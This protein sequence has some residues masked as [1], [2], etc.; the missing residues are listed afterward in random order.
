[1]NRFLLFL[2]FLFFLHGVQ[3]QYTEDELNKFISSSSE[4][5]QVMETSLLM[6][7][8]FY[9]YAEKIT[10]NLLSRQPDNC[11][12][13]YRK[14]YLIVLSRSDYFA[15]LP[16]L[17]KAITSL[18]KNFDR[19]SA[20]EKSAS[21]DALYYLACCYHAIG[22]TDDATELFRKFISMSDKKATLVTLSRLKIKQCEL[23]KELMSHPNVNVSVK[24]AGPVINSKYPEYSAI[25]ALDGSALFYTSRRPWEDGSSDPYVD[26]R[27]NL[28]PEDVYVS[29][30]D[31]NN[32]WMAPQR[33]SF[34][35]SETFEATVAV[36]MDERRVYVYKDDTG[37]GDIY[38]SDFSQ[39]RFKEMEFL[40]IKDVNTKYW[41]PHAT[42]NPE[43]TAMYIVSDRPGGYGGRDIYQCLKQKDGTWG[44]PVN[45]GPEINS[46]YD[47]DAPFISIDGKQFYFSTNGPKSMG[48]FDIL[49]SVRTSKNKWSEAVNLGYPINSCGDDLY[50][51]TTIDGYHGYFTSFRQD[52]SGEKDIYEVTNNYLG[53]KDLCFLKGQFITADH[54]AL[55]ENVSITFR[56][57]D[58]EE[59]GE[60]TVF[61]RLRDGMIIKMLEPCKEYEMV[62]KAENKELLRENIKTACDVH[63]SIVEKNMLLDVDKMTLVPYVKKKDTVI[64]LEEFPLVDMK[65]LESRH[66]FRYDD[67]KLSMKGRDL[68]K[69]M[70][71]VEDQLKDRNGNITVKVYSSASNV[72]TRRYES[73]QKLADLRAENVKYDIVTHFQQKKKY[74]GRV[75]VVIVSSVVE[76]PAYENDRHNQEKY[77]PFQFVYLRTE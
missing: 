22:R 34:C 65:P 4:Q 37:E 76:G 23:A 58:C 35:K 56:C 5:D 13:N 55:P 62:Y 39:N 18:N 74:A 9:H 51:T 16:Y 70:R 26:G 64:V 52:G 48:G 40:D 72:P 30:L 15:A 10:D 25:V 20:S 77:Q 29:Y 12:Y 66:F 45:M 41:E 73:N 21:I 43:G 71:A 75:N 61:P 69:F 46:A 36:N 49:M 31:S 24:N 32:N 7:Q 42:V 67:N 59:K 27:N 47:E 1:M 17:E 8:G 44:K 14:G 3:G 28:H 50:Y 60:Q 38:F 2:V 54:K 6:D 63:Y 19:N 57:N 53:V 11:N 33:L 68:R